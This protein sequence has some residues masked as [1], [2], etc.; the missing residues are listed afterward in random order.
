MQH[1]GVIPNDGFT[2]YWLSGGV[3]TDACL[4]F[5]GFMCEKK[6]KKNMNHFL[7]IHKWCIMYNL[8]KYSWNMTTKKNK[9]WEY[10]H[11]TV[12]REE[13]ECI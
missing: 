6:K 13:T 2:K 11:K 4:I 1:L 9:E 5:L 12:S 7:P 3:N 8:K 10:F